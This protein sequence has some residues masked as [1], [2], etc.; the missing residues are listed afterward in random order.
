[1]DWSSDV[2]SSDL[3]DI[4][5]KSHSSR[6]GSMVEDIVQHSS[7]HQAIGMSEPFRKATNRLKDYLFMHVYG[8]DVRG[9][10]ELEYAGQML[11][12]LFRFYMAHPD[13]LHANGTEHSDECKDTVQLARRV[14]DFISG[15]TDRYAQKAHASL[16]AES[17]SIRD[18]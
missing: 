15:M 14:C 9:I 1:C 7:E 6:I 12:E 13:Q 3:V 10:A 17:S 11:K 8:R 2:C 4:L 5:G 18:S 16:A